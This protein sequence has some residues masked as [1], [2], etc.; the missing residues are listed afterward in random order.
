M[1]IERK[2]FEALS[3]AVAPGRVVAVYGPRQCGK[4][5]LVRRYVK[6]LKGRILSTTG[7]DSRIASVLG[8]FAADEY[9]QSFGDLDFLFIDEAQSVRQIGRAL[10]LL[11]DTLPDLRVVVSG[12]SSFELAGQVGEPLVGRKR[13]VTLYP[14][15]FAEIADADSVMSARTRLGEM[16]QWGTYPEVWLAGGERARREALME[17][18]EGYLFKDVI[19]FESLR[20]SD[21][22][23]RL[24]MLLAFQVGKEVSLSEL[25][26]NLGIARQTVERYL[27]LLEKTFVV[28]K[29][30]GFSRNLRGEIVKMSRWYFNDNGVMNAV[31]GIL[32]PPGERGDAGVL[33]ENWIMGERRKYLAW[34]GRMAKRYFWRTYAQ[35]EIDSVEEEDG[36]LSAWEF[37]WGRKTPRV[38]AAWK[39]AYPDASFGVIGP[40]NML[41]FIV[42]PE[43]GRS[44]MEVCK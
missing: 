5:T 11:V 40:E 41:Q 34:T 20:N 2:A 38:P 28:Y 14:L 27:D 43:G 37:K 44:A 9:R 21:K 12:S 8:T 26:T 6:T 23:R 17:L 1:Y 33:W 42:E 31:T 13:T 25:A 3:S 16:M 7:E 32:R 15:A 18:V 24:L 4:T 35:S 30:P 19:A 29:V 39:T 22:I 10:K 36:R